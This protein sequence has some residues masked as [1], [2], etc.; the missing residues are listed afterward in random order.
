VEE[1]V[2]SSL[3][4]AHCGAPIITNQHATRFCSNACRLRGF[5]RRKAGLSE[6]AYPDGAL[7]GRVALSD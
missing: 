3:K 2:D 1:T 6:R 4:C 5:R 7:R